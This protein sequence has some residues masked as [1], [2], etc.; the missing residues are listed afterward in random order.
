M[1]CH[2]R[3]PG[4]EDCVKEGNTVFWVMVPRLWSNLPIPFHLSPSLKVLKQSFNGHSRWCNSLLWE[5]FRNIGSWLTS[6]Q[7][8]GSSS[9]GFWLGMGLPSPTGRCHGL[10]LRASACKAIALFLSYGLFPSL[11]VLVLNTLLGMIFM[12]FSR[13]HFNNICSVSYFEGEKSINT[14]SQ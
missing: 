14:R 4:E 6:S 2:V 5:E 9:L 7:S 1:S 13:Y 12:C 8:I 10:Y 3:Y 11:C